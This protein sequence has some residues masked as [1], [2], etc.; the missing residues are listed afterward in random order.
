MIAIPLQPIPA[1]TFNISLAGQ[2]CR[3]TLYQKGDHFYLDL[4]VNGVVA[5]QSRMV[6]NSAWIVR[7][8]YLGL[9]GDLVMFDTQGT[10]DSPTY[11]GLGTRYQ[12]YY[13]T[14]DELAAGALLQRSFAPPKPGSTPAITISYNLPSA[15]VGSNYSGSITASLAGGAIGA[16]R[17]TVTG[18]QSGWILGTAI[19]N[20]NGSWT[21]PVTGVTGGS[22]GI[23]TVHIVADNGNGQTATQDVEVTVNAS[24]ET[25]SISLTA[26]LPNGQFEVA[27]PGGSVSGTNQNGAT[28]TIT[29][30]VDSLPVGMSLDSGTGAVTGTPTAQDETKDVTFTPTFTATNGTQSATLKVNLL[31][32]AASAAPSIN[33]SADMPDGMF[34][35]A[36][37][38]SVSATNE[39]GATG[40]MAYSVD[41][42]PTGMSL[43][44]ASGAVTGTPTFTDET[45]NKTYT[46][47]FVASNGTQSATLKVTFVIDAAASIAF[48][49]DLPAGE[50]GQPYDGF[51]TAANVGS[52]TGDI[53]LT[54]TGLQSGLSLG[55]GLDNGD[56]SWTW[57]VTGTLAADAQTATLDVQATNGTQSASATPR[58]VVSAGFQIVEKQAFHYSNASTGTLTFAS[59]IENND[60][61]LIL[62]QLGA[63]EPTFTITDTNQRTYAQTGVVNAGTTVGAYQ[64]LSDYQPAAAAGALVVTAQASVA[65]YGQ[66]VAY[67]L[68]GK[69]ISADAANVIEAHQANLTGTATLANYTLDPS[70]FAA[71]SVATFQG[72]TANPVT[73]SGTSV[74]DYAT[75]DT[76][77]GFKTLFA[78]HV[79][80]VSASTAES[81]KITCPSG[82]TN[83][84]EAHV[85]VPYILGDPPTT[86][87]TP[88]SGGGGGGGGSGGNTDG[89]TPSANTTLASDGATFTILDTSTT[90]GAS[91]II[92]ATLTFD[93]GSAPLTIRAGRQIQ[94]T[95]ATAGK[96]TVGFSCTD[97]NN[98]TASTTLE[99]TTTND[100][101]LPAV[102]TGNAGDAI[103]YGTY[104]GGTP[105]AVTVPIGQRVTIPGG[106]GS[107]KHYTGK[108]IRV[109]NMYETCTNDLFVYA[110]VS[111]IGGTELFRG[112]LP[113]WA[114]AG[115]RP[116]WYEQPQLLA[117]PDTTYVPK[118]DPAG[119]SQNASGYS[120]WVGSDNSPMG[121]GPV[122]AD[123]GSEGE[124]NDMGPAWSYWDACYVVNP[125]AENAQ[126]MRWFSDS[127]SVWPFHCISSATNEMMTAVDYPNATMYY[128]PTQAPVPGNPIQVY[129]PDT[130][131]WLNLEEAQ[132]HCVPFSVGAAVYF[133]TDYDKEQVSEWTNYVTSLWVI[134]GDRLSSGCVTA[135]NGQV[136]GVGRGLAMA[137]YASK[138]SADTALFETYASTLLTD[139]NRRWP[140]PDD[141][142]IHDV[143]HNEGYPHND[144]APWM[145]D[146]LIHGLGVAIATG[147]TDAQTLLDWFAVNRLDS[148][149]NAQHEFATVYGMAQYESDGVTLVANWVAALNV[150]A[151]YDSKIAN[152]LPCA[153]NSQALQDALHPGVP[154][155]VP[156]DFAQSAG[157]MNSYARMMQLS[158]AVIAR[159]GTDQTRAQAAWTKFLQYVR[160]PFDKYSVLP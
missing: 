158:L 108:G 17:L 74:A 64:Y 20:G 128:D 146:F 19:D 87:P 151:T 123:M 147:H 59:A 103:V 12:L 132:A 7:Y 145:T 13:L 81:V 111:T 61:V 94:H 122:R 124:D 25:P 148:M 159:Y 15:T 102:P 141:G 71:V 143:R 73:F 16:T 98:N 8:G 31:I 3:I 90:T 11:D 10:N 75:S 43:D 55:D 57:E 32:T 4:T 112:N 138:L 1:Q 101:V 89:M 133:G 152:A 118:Y 86:I 49:F 82:T 9:V 144:Y 121:S 36:Y 134:P 47:T 119:M 120:N 5:L 93:D 131:C 99:L 56:G 40:T 97:A 137:C 113:V 153:E 52:A 139:I 154:G 42:L 62:F 140:A 130:A 117:S 83:V 63:A 77:S 46:A 115:T 39:N 107:V 106:V 41:A 24:A 69:S 38:G 79:L 157:N 150:E 28:G 65:I 44:S 53:T 34:G 136:R 127:A 45:V 80:P 68:R 60:L 22:A 35:V 96:H 33:M 18:L 66:A 100:V 95:W 51:I 156:G 155:Y 142:Y 6:L 50:A 54:V 23:A 26:N 48:T 37:N 2:P 105:F 116:F 14:P 30:S 84:T 29:Y 125:T 70:K 76:S 58:I 85:I 91:K 129:Y 92:N 109:E 114:H 72:G 104:N 149:L 126:V 135:N 78:G 21:W 88:P 110:V 67:L 160:G 27:Y